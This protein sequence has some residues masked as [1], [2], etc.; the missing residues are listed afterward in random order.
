M[1]VESDPSGR[2]HWLYMHSDQQAGVRPCFRTGLMDDMWSYLHIDHPAGGLREPGRLRHVVLASDATAF[3]LGGDLDLFCR[4]I[5]ATTASACWPMRAAASMASTTCTTVSAATSARSRSS[6]ATRW[7][8]ASNW[9]WPARRSSPRK[10]SGWACRKS[11]SA[12]SRAWAPIRSCASAWPA[13]RRED[14]PRR[15]HPS[16]E[17]LYRMGIVDVLVPKGEGERAVQDII[18]Q[19]QRAPHA[20]LALQR[21]PCDRAAGRATTN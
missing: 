15:H 11:C 16:S 9:R 12:S 5:R 6:R 2:E 3:N 8:A 20:H 18:R 4:L 13:A 21:R 14:H 1:R 10:A 19:Q 7:A 17:E